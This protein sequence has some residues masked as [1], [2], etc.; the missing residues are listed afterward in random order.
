VLREYDDHFVPQRVTGYV[1][2][3]KYHEGDVTRALATQFFEDPELE[4]ILKQFTLEIQAEKKMQADGQEQKYRDVDV[5]MATN[6]TALISNK[7]NN[8]ASLTIVSG[9]GDFVP[10]V[11]KAKE[12]GIYTIVFSFKE[13]LATSTG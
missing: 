2:A 9:D 11:N 13:N 1:Y 12:T 7:G 4:L 6:A 5:M 10:V 8:V 3:S